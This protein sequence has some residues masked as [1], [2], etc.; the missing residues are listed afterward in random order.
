MRAEGV[1]DYYAAPLLFADGSIHSS[2]WTTKQPGGFSDEQLDGLRL[3]VVPLA[4]LI[5]IISLRR[6]AS[7]LLDTYVGNRAGERILGG[8]IRRG[9]T[10]TMHAPIWLSDLRGFTALSDRLPAAH[11]AE[12]PNRYFDCPGSS[13]RSHG[14]E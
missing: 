14:G 11:A 12:I 6:R 13:I 8:Q 7:T 10:H 1:T 3:T 9:H 5:E 4:R 2:S